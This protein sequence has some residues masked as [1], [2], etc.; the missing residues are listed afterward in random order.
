MET[1]RSLCLIAMPDDHWVSFDLKDGLYSVAID[2]KEREMSTVDL[3]V[4]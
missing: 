1:P 2:P 3:D 4:L